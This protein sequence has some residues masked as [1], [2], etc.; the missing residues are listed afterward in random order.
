MARR[1]F[2][3]VD[4]E[5]RARV[6]IEPGVQR[7]TSEISWSASSV[8]PAAAQ[9]SFTTTGSNPSLMQPCYEMLVTLARS[10]EQG[11]SVSRSPP[12]TLMRLTFSLSEDGNETVM[13]L[14]LISTVP[15]PVSAALEM[16]DVRIGRTNR[17]LCV[18][19]QLG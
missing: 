15:G 9:T 3:A 14:A 17:S 4:T 2:M 5:T 1:V 6:R 7:N 16:S 19:H 12:A 8:Q 13:S 10:A 11:G 18:L